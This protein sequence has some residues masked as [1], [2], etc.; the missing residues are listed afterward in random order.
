MSP[1]AKKKKNEYEGWLPERDRFV[2]KELN[3]LQMED[4]A[5][6]FREQIIK[7]RVPLKLSGGFKDTEF[8]CCQDW[9]DEF[10]ID[11]TKDDNETVR[12]EVS[13]SGLE[14]GKGKREYMKFSEFMEKFKRGD[15]SVYISASG[16]RFDAVDGRPEI[17][18]APLKNL[19]NPFKL[20]GIDFRRKQW[21]NEKRERDLTELNGR[22]KVPTRP[23]LMSFSAISTMN[24]W[25]GRGLR[26]ET[27]S[28]LH[29]DFHDNLYVVLRGFKRFELYAPS[30][31]DKMYMSGEVKKVH[32]NGLICYDDDTPSY[33][34]EF[35]LAKERVKR[36]EKEREE[37]GNDGAKMKCVNKKK[38]INDDDDD[39]DD[40]DKDDNSEEDFDFDEETF[41]DDY[42][43]SDDEDAAADED[44]DDDDKRS[45]NDINNNNKRR[46][47][48]DDDDDDD[49]H[50][51]DKTKKTISSKLPKNFSTVDK[52]DL[53][54][55]PKFKDAHKITC[56]LKAGEMLFLPAG[57]FHEVFS[58]EKNI[59]QTREGF[60]E[61]HMALN[62]WF[63]PY[64]DEAGEVEGPVVT[65]DTKPSRR[66]V[67]E[68]DYENWLRR[69]KWYE[70]PE[71]E[72]LGEYVVPS[73]SDTEER[74]RGKKYGPPEMEQLGEYVVPSNSHKEERERVKKYIDE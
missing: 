57:W 22:G 46:K 20:F 29:H 10:L 33:G 58:S 27:S 13:S 12:V 11:R 63:Q 47:A 14:F 28:G 61:G 48:N 5:E 39:D 37:R 7:E 44:F 4:M 1:S 3:L 25:M 35:A 50:I 56:E 23:K 52:D 2:I 55:F 43:D 18:S 51:K 32:R 67:W 73:D 68:R 62:Y 49:D 31:F 45:R 66:M 71:M 24:L 72:Q 30:E 17:L 19:V 41:V 54:K 34:K 8:E 65:N 36:E 9:D 15:S 16:E 64:S 59:F 70:P 42:V 6:Q 21:S 60:D 38:H 74:E 26:G 53:E 69:Q 40:D